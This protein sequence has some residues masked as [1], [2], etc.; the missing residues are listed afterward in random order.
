MGLKIV[1]QS[2]RGIWLLLGLTSSTTALATNGYFS[3]AYSVKTEG[4]AGVG[5]AFPQD[6]LTIAT[7]PA[8]LVSISDT[9]DAGLDVFLPQ[10]EATLVQGGQSQSFDGSD[11]NSFY[12]PSVGYARHLSPNVAVGVALFGNG[13]LNTD[14]ASNPFARFGATGSAGVDLEQLFLSPAISWTINPK[15]EVGIAANIAYQRFKAKGIGIFGGFSSDPGAVSDRGYDNS[16]GAGVRVGWIGHVDEYLAVGGTWQSKTYMSRF[17]KYA[18]L[19]ADSGAFDI[20]STYGLGLALT[21]NAAWTVAVDWQEIRYSGIAAVGNPVNSLFSGVPL[22]AE[23]GPGFGWRN[24]SVFKIGA[25]FNV[26]PQWTLRAGFSDNRQPIPASQTF[27]NILAPGVVETHATAG[28]TWRASAA[29]EF[30]VSALHA[31]KK[32]VNGSGSIPPSFG[33]GE[34]NISLEETSV[35]LSW[36]HHF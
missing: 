23:N 2:F 21:P 1:R 33:G 12:I 8:G 5:I 17:T 29:N 3:S 9:F 28:L 32:T 27:F 11:K 19:F 6:S 31:F 36:S 30:S 16:Y 26:N 15:N 24:V 22:G 35:G 34:A 7:N 4:V 14:Y 20:P 10:R 18:G 25:I 13:G